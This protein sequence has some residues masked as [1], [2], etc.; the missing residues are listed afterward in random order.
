MAWNTTIQLSKDSNARGADV[1][2]IVLV[3]TLTAM[4]VHGYEPIRARYFRVAADGSLVYL[5]PAD[6]AAYDASGNASAQSAAASATTTSNRTPY[7]GSPITIPATIEAENFD[8][9][10]EGAGYHDLSATNTGGQYRTSEG[11]DIV[12]SNDP[13]GGGYVVN[14]FQN[15][16]WLSYTINVPAAGNYD[17][18]VRAVTNGG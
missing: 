15:G 8:K 3:Q 16:E 18:D 12:A 1:L 10:G 6:V 7:S 11:V 14:N 9:G 13:A 2:P 5:T 4:A 17:I